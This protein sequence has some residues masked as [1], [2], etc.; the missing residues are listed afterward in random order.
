[1]FADRGWFCW[2][3]DNGIV[4]E[5]LIALKHDELKEMGIVSAGH[6]LT[7]LKSVY[8]TKVKQGIEPDP[9]DYIPL[10]MSPNQLRRVKHFGSALLTFIRFFDS[11]GPKHERKCD[12]RG[13]RAPT[14]VDPISR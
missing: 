3:V 7:I 1:L 10:C 13:F 2:V 14:S 8:A 4:G 9:D 12:T 5:V 11:R 6:R